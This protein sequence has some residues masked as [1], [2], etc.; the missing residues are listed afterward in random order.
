MRY[1]W[2]GL[3]ADVNGKYE[4]ILHGRVET[5]CSLLNILSKGKDVVNNSQSVDLDLD[6]DLDQCVANHPFTGIGA[7]VGGAQLAG[8]IDSWLLPEQI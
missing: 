7:T 6:L 5:M 8:T 2:G 1:I 4:D 3:K